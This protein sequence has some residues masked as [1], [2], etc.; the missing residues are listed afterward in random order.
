[1]DR[2]APGRTPLTAMY[3][4][5]RA[6]E[7]K[8]NYMDGSVPFDDMNQ[9]F[10]D[11]MAEWSNLSVH[12]RVALAPARARH[13]EETR[14]LLAARRAALEAQV[15]GELGTAAAEPQLEPQPAAAS[16]ALPSG[17]AASLRQSARF[18]TRARP[19]SKAMESE[20]EVEAKDLEL[21]ESRVAELERYLGIEDMDLQYFYE[22]DGEDLNKK[23]QMLEDFIRAAEDKLFV[24]H[25]LFAKYEKLENFLK[26]NEPFMQQCMDLKQ[27]ANFIIDNLDS[28][29]TFLQQIE[30]IKQKENFLG[31]EPIVDAHSKL[32]ELK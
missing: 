6:G 9:L 20:F 18:S 29:Q 11:S 5:Q 27:K 13:V 4:Q 1:M 14:G 24:L 23:S 30:Q 21:L 25:D 19:V 16:P 10:R 12:E 32:Q 7:T 31:F 28:L 17:K 8:A 3:I 22:L 26:H 2:K 15:A